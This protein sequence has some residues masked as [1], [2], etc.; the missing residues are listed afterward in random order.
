[1]ES[2]EQYSA[3]PFEDSL[4]INPTTNIGTLK[5]LNKKLAMVRSKIR[6]HPQTSL[7]F[8]DSKSNFI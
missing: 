3:G 6:F 8:T 7:I 2:A 1:V 5:K 4:T